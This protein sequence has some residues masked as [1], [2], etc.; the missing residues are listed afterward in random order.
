MYKT[1]LGLKVRLESESNG[2]FEGN[3][4]GRKLKCGS[5]IFLF[6]VVNKNFLVLLNKKVGQLLSCQ[7]LHHQLLLNTLF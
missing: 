5:Y 1:N 7:K 4:Q 3:F 6:A 2:S